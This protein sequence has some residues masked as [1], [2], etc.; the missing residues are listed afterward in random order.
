M[1][2]SANKPLRILVMAGG[3][4]GHVFP[5]LAVA[6]ELRARGVEVTWL[7]SRRGLEAEVVP[8]AGYPIDYINVS[9]LRGKGLF[10]WLLA[11]I[12]LVMAL[13]QGWAIMRRRHPSAVLGMGGFVSGPGG[14]AAWLTRRPLLI[15][16]QNARAG[17]TNRLLAPLANRVMEAFPGSLANTGNVL[18]TGNPLRREFVESSA[19]GNESGVSRDTENLNVSGDLRLLVVGGSLG[20]MKLNEVVPAALATLPEDMR[21]EV[22][23]QTGKRN[24]GSCQAA[25]KNSGIDAR[26]VPFISDMAEAYRWADLVICRAGAMTIAELAAVGVASIL[27]PFPFAV[28]DHQTANA[29]YLSD[30]NAAVLLPQKQLTPER[31]GELIK[32]ATPMSL[33]KMAKAARSMALLDASQRV[34]DQCLEVVHG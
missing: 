19:A 15:H 11:P 27:V 3:T 4:G 20:A 14:L 29:H 8:E 26:I 33:Q 1:N 13:M 24:I 32:E 34:A 16:E 5:A 28:D 21:P 10:S 17:L 6:D 12:K 22:W 2:N 9:G 7:G 31:L 23:H 25:Y 30:K 18:H